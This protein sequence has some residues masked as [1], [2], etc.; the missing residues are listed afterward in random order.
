MLTKTAYID[1]VTARTIDFA[2]LPVS[3]GKSSSSSSFSLPVQVDLRHLHV[4][5]ATIEQ[6]VAGAAATLS[7]DGSGYL[8]TLT[9]GTIHLDARR[10]DSPGGEYQVNGTVGAHHIQA[11]VKANEPPKGLIST[12]AKLPD[13]GAIAIQAS[14]D[15]PR[16]ALVTQAG[17]SAGQLKASASGT[18][19]LDHEAADLAVN[20]QAPAM[21]PAPGVSWQSVLVDAKVKGPFTKPDATGTVRIKA[22]EAGGAKIGAIDADVAGN[23]GQVEMH[24]TITDL[25]VPGPKPDV[26]A[27]APVKLDVTAQLAAPGRPVTFAIHHPLIAIDGSAQTEG[28]RQ[29]QAHVVVADLTPLAALGGV[30]IQGSTDLNLKAAMTGNTTMAAVTGK[31]GI[32]GGMAPV[33]ALIGPDGSIDAAAELRGQDVTLQ[34]LTVNGKALQ[35]SAQGG[36]ANQVIDLDWGVKL[37]DLTAVAPGVSGTVEANGKASGKTDDLAVTAHIGADVAANGFP[38]GHVTAQVNAA[39]LPTAPHAAVTADGT[40]LNAPLS[41]ALNADRTDGTIH[42]TIDHLDWKSLQGQA[43]VTL[44]SGAILPQGTV[45]VT[46]T[47]LADLQPL[48]GQAIAGDAAVNLDSDANAARADVS[49]KNAALPGTASISAL[50]LKATVTDPASH[51]MIDGTLT[52][53]GVSASTVHGASAQ[54]TAKG[55]LDALATTIA[56]NAPDVAG[57][58]ARLTT[59][60]TVNA[61]ARSVA[62]QTMEASWKQQ[63][64]RLLG[65]TTIALAD[66]VS[67][68]HL[69]LGFQQAVLSVSGTAGSKLDLTASL[70]N[71]PADVA[72]IADPTLAMDGTIQADAHLTG[73]SARPEGTVRLTAS[74]VRLRQGPGRGLPPANLTANANLEGTQVQINSRVTAGPSHLT[75]TGTAPLSK[76]GTL[77]IR[78]DGRVDL[79][80]LDPIVAAQG[81]RVRGIVTLNATATGTTTAPRVNGSMILANG[82]VTDFGAGV[83]IS[84]IAATVQATGDTI[85]LTRFSGKAGPGTLGGSGTI[86]LAGEMP[87]DLRFTADNARPIS[88]DLVTALINANLTVQ[89]QVKGDLTAG[90]T[91]TIRRADIRIPETIPASVAVLPIYNPNAPP[92]PAPPQ[93]GPS[94]IA[95]NLTISAPEQVFIRGRGLNAELGGTIHIGGTTANPRPSGGFHLRRGDLSIIGTTLNFTSGTIDFNGAGISDPEINFVAT[96]TNA[97]MT[98]T[99][100][101]SG[102][103]KNPKITLSSVPELPQDEI[104]AQILF[105]TSASK[106]SPLQL[107]Q[108]AAAL[109]SLSGATSGV[110]DPLD[111]LRTAL[112]LDRLTIGSD[113][114]GNPSLQAGRYI[115]RGVYVGAI[116]SASGNGT[117]AT[118]QVDL[119]KGL[120]A[121]ATAGTGTTNATGSTSTDAASVGLTYQFQY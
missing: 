24:A 82:D 14:V 116:Q 71:L 9:E 105:N 70:R 98:A 117:Q 44:P 54:V 31:V 17:I 115:A 86:S 104:L 83:H 15:G 6:A 87:V 28:D 55:P 66:G 120:K 92:A 114:A 78:T 8:Q 50:L 76:D 41:L 119:A 94:M 51:P 67:I 113:A 84:D 112:G 36:I 13:L 19:D 38:S 7:L 60:G 45:H 108:I 62:L 48:I 3:S 74:N 30:D 2:R 89:G 88:S 79:T 121:V 37:A 85:T 59:A 91:V 68:Q 21:T 25:H 109:A 110:G 10:L 107:A 11:S 106:L 29:A 64:L 81:R 26:L 95:L 33:P 1:N 96:T 97:T 16:D 77:N 22:L 80:M 46:M 40:L 32:I 42:A 111:K 102:D 34:H 5:Q 69:R 39:G 75:A 27:T 118:V 103:V 72:A 63:V 57:G 73:T 18:V 49:V 101:I 61:T 65:P 12:L 90:G 53:D 99:L 47:R 58:P 100:T 4:D 23:A 56:A 20:A 52:A 93:S 43:N 35:V